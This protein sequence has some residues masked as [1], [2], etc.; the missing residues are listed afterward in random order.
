[1]NHNKRVDFWF[2]VG[3]G[4]DGCRWNRRFDDTREVKRMEG[5]MGHELLIL[6]LE[7]E[8]VDIKTL[9]FENCFSDSKICL[10]NSEIMKNGKEG[11]TEQMWYYLQFKYPYSFWFMWQHSHTTQRTN[12][13]NKHWVGRN[14]CKWQLGFTKIFI[15]CQFET[16]KNLMVWKIICITAFL[17]HICIQFRK[18]SNW[19]FGVDPAHT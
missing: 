2:N 19:K 8:S 18:F 15:I 12:V 6:W 16:Q 1:M 10:F 7:R 17:L 5:S 3:D 11:K 9:N 13:Q 4:I 14:V